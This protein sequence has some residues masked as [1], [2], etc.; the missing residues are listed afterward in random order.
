MTPTGFLNQRRRSTA[1]MPVS[2][3]APYSLTNSERH[4]P[5]KRMKQKPAYSSD[6]DVF[7]VPLLS[8][9]LQYQAMLSNA[10]ASAAPCC[11]ARSSLQHLAALLDTEDTKT[12]VARKE[13]HNLTS[14]PVLL[15][16]FCVACVVHCSSMN[17]AP[18]KTL[19]S[20]RAARQL[21]SLKKQM[22]YSTHRS[23]SAVT[24]KFTREGQS[25]KN[26]V[27]LFPTLVHLCGSKGNKQK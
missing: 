7:F 3:M 27:E 22:I 8:L 20:T 12:A 10:A 4:S 25:K 17:M 16:F 23:W 2:S 13:R 11:M 19:A 1:T 6:R 18:S 21:L 24:R 9:R 15:F 26:T 14:M 5:L